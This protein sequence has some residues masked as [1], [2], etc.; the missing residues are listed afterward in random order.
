M[1]APVLR[2]Y[3]ESAVRDI[4]ATFGNGVRR[5]LL[6]APTG[7]GKTVLFSYIAAGV[8]AK[9]KRVAIIA[10]RTELLA[11]ISAALSMF[12]VPHAVLEGGTRGLPRAQVT[13]AS[14]FTLARRLAHFAP[15]DLVV[16]DECFAAGT[17]IDGRPIEGIRSGDAVFSYNHHA[18]AVE[19]RTVTH[20]FRRQTSMIIRVMLEDGQCLVC[21]PNHPFYVDGRYISA[22]ELAPDDM[23]LRKAADDDCPEMR[24]VREANVS[25]G[26]RSKEVLLP[27]VPVGSL[28]GEMAVRRVGKKAEEPSGSENDDL[29]MLCLRSDSDSSRPEPVHA[30]KERVL[31]EG[32]Q[33]EAAFGVI[34]G[35]DG[36]DEPEICRRENASEQPNEEAGDTAIGFGDT[37][38]HASWPG[39]SGR[40]RSASGGAPSGV[41]GS[42]GVAN[43]IR[44]SDGPPGDGI[45]DSLQDRHSKPD[46]EDRGG[47]GRREPQGYE[48]QGAGRSQRRVFER[49]RVASVEV[50]ERGRDIEFDRL[51]PDGLVYNL[52]VD[53]NNNYFAAGV[54]VHNCHHCVTTTTFGKV[55]AYFKDSL[56]LG[57]TATP[58]RLDGQGLGDVFHALILGPSTADLMDRGYLTPAE[59]YAPVEA[60]DLSGIRTR[61]GDYAIDQLSAAMDKPKITGNAVEHYRKLAHGKSAVAFCC[62]I[63]HATDVA[64]E[65]TAAGY[66]AASV[67]GKM[68][69]DKRKQAIAD[70]TSGRL[71]ILTSCDLISEGVDVPR[72][73]CGIMLRPTQ[74]TGLWL[75]QVG[76]TLRPYPGKSAAII[77]DH[78]GNAIAHGLPDDPRQWSLAGSERKKRGEAGAALRTCPKCLAIHRPA[79]KCPRCGHVYEVIGRKPE[80]VEGELQRVVR[81]NGNGGDPPEVDLLERARRRD[82]IRKA[83]SREALEE[84][85]QA[86]GYAKGWVYHV[87]QSRGEA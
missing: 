44:H 22:I 73:E 14:V 57:V 16:V 48:G 47:S 58:V 32:V 11:Q 86:R 12:R 37:E 15:P 64:A 45:P 4:R 71:Q 24:M 59:V 54:L 75:Q 55:T 34:V 25:A 31:R 28:A 23:V 77:L 70:L 61:A 69:R 3:Q 40:Q 8:A 50:F 53:G 6:T 80:A 85:A 51:C 67:D 10:H 13:V 29:G 7:S 66:R 62:S 2:D 19:A 83:R 82:E 18:D 87:L 21:T 43:G 46:H 38:S 36:G 78:A 30:G 65:F 27:G 42:I 60:V 41:S 39:Y 68:D 84:I 79:P 52:E 17:M 5:V 74:S 35:Y 63:Q 56:V 72:I 33:Q 1:A 76:R 26:L 20:T 9:G 81:Q 49:I